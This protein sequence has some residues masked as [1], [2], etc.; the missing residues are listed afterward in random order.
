ML[1]YCVNTPKRFAALVN[2][3]GNPDGAPQ[4]SASRRPDMLLALFTAN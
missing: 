3:D 1:Y 2:P 4:G